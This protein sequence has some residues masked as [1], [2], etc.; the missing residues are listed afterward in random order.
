MRWPRTVARDEDSA[1][2][3]AKRI[4]TNLY[5]ERPTWLAHAHAKLDEAV[6]RAYG[7]PADLSD[8]QILKKLLALNLERTTTNQD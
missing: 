1:K 7:W 6:F 5:N 3:L 4:F 2:L 8:E